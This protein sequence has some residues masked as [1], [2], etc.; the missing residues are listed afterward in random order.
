MIGVLNFWSSKSMQSHPFLGPFWMF[1]IE[2]F[3]IFSFDFNF[4]SF[5]SVQEMVH[6]IHLVPD[7]LV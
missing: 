7:T 5:I 1:D 4:K 3:C 2:N 6:K